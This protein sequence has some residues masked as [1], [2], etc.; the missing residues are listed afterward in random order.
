MDWANLT[1]FY[2]VGSRRFDKKRTVTLALTPTTNGWSQRCADDPALNVDYVCG[3]NLRELKEWFL[4]D[5]TRF[6]LH[7]TR[8]EAL[9]HRDGADEA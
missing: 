6:T 2:V 4:C 1:P 9:A 8:E 3:E 7:E 5:C